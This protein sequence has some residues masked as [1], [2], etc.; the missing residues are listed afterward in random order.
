MIKF[1]VA[2]IWIAAVTVGSVYFS[3]NSQGAATKEKTDLGYFGGLDYVKT[4]MISV[5]VMKNF[6]VDGYFLAR[7]VYTIEPEKA[8]ALS[9]PA[10][11]LL[12]DLVYTY[13][14]ANPQIDFVTRG[15]LDLD[16]MRNGIRD[17]VNARVGDK[18]VHEVLV[19]QID[20][21]SKEEIRGNSVRQR[22]E[23]FEKKK[24]DAASG[25]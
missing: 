8:K 18:L 11:P 5:P 24:S 9:L 22:A 23:P 3:F 6:K 2:A 21:L 19:E 7:L 16:A 15:N 20:Y 1:V 25:H 10:E 13:L 4:E 12:T 14:Y 17:S